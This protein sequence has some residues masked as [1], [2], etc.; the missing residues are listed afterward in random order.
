MPG[1]RP[2]SSAL[3][4]ASAH[5]RLLATKLTIPPPRPHLVARPHLLERLNQGLTYRLILISGPAGFGKTTLLSEWALEAGRHVA[6]LSLDQADN[7]PTRF[8]MYA[9]AALQ[10]IREGIGATALAALQ[11]PQPPAMEALLTSLINDIAASGSDPLVLVLDDVHLIT[12]PPIH[13]ALLFLVDHLPPTMHLVL[14]ARADPPWPLARLRAMGDMIEVRTDDLR[15]TAAEVAAFLND[16]MG[17]GL[18]AADIAALDERTEGWIAGLQ[19]AALSLQGRTDAPALIQSFRGSHRFILDYLV[20]EVLER[21]PGDV[22]EF[23]YQTAVLDRLTAP[24]CDAVTGRQDSQA[25]LI[26]LERANLFLVPLDDER[27]WYRYH[28]LFADLLRARLEGTQPGRAAVLHRRASAWYEGQQMIVEAMTHALAAHDV[29][30]A[31][32]LA[33]ENV[34]GMMEHG[35]LGVLVEWLNALP[36]EL[37]R[38]RPW[39][40]IARAWALAF[41]G[42]FEA[43]TPC[44]QDA[45][46]AVEDPPQPGLGVEGRGRAPEEVAHVKGHIDAIRCYVLGLTFGE[47][48]QVVEL[49]QSALAQ[50]PESDWR[51]RGFVAVLLGLGHRL[52]LNYAAAHEALARGLAIARAAKQTYVV[53]DVLCQIAL[54]ESDQGRLH[55]A[56]ATCR[57]ALREAG[58][59]VGPGHSRL[60]LAS[61]ALHAL[62]EILHEWNEGDAA[63]ACAQEALALA[64]QWGDAD[65]LSGAYWTLVKVRIAR[66]EFARALE[67]IEE[68]ARLGV[69]LP[70][71]RR[72]AIAMEAL[73]R[74]AMNDLAAASRRV[75]ELAACTD[76]DWLMPRA[77][78]V[79]L[80]QFRHGLRPSLDDVLDYLARSLEVAEAAGA[81]PAIA[82][83]LVYQAMA[84]QATGRGEQARAALTRALAL[85]EPEGYVRTFID[86]GAPMGELL[87]AVLAAQ[88]AR[89]AKSDR[90]LA[91]YASRLL[92]TLE[93]KGSI[94][95]PAETPGERPAAPPLPAP[96]EPLSAREMEVLR[97]LATTLSTPEIARELVVSTNTVRSHVKC[98]YS[99]LNVHGRIEA[100]QRA[101]EL[102]LLP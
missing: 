86:E 9:V 13:D 91:S 79:Y 25:V 50:L 34:L 69:R 10:T 32:R 49:A 72:G 95:S 19:M 99:K 56:A 73:V 11:S 30:R 40:C 61:Y 20:E 64:Q 29:G 85:A 96:L 70:R 100:L 74:L 80:A 102:G 39:L 55:Q 76:E 43:V 7:E 45:A 2:V 22:Q 12:A 88:P 28:H 46:Q 5:S 75:D 92:A 38:S 54:V 71:Y 67:I 59:Y 84:L 89:P 24:L 58:E 36:S 77:I 60:P 42:A 97:L 6:W 35:N 82:K 48:R 47:Y 78:P 98:I 93:T 53:I 68:R 23:L 57:E 4:E 31:A 62:G 51:A 101:R 8:W 1:A 63:L 87:A 66:R 3:P 37:V 90:R 33:E 44:L 16:V 15:F 94:T 26:R 14:S 18:S 65:S 81:Q 83:M 27:C 17:L 52:N 21:Q 41:T